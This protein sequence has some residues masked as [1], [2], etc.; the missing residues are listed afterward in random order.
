MGL[1]EPNL[2]CAATA[3]A[4]GPAAMGGPCGAL[5]GGLA[6]LGRLWGRAQPQEKDDPLLWKTCFVYYKRFESEVVGDRSSVNCRDITGVEWSD[7]EQARAFY[8]G[9]GLRQCTRTTGRAA[10]I[11]GEILEKYAA[12]EGRGGA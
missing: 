8:Q 10:R 7:R 9:E 4:G 2:L 11:L 3:L 5:T 12:A 6:L 1:N